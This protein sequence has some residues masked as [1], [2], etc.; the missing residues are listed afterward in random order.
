MDGPILQILVQL[1]IV[2]AFLWWMN[3]QNDRWD[4]NNDQWREYL[5]ERNSKL[6]K[7]LEKLSGAIDRFHERLDGK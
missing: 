1:P 4:K 2:A 7:S 3:R 6:E 5:A